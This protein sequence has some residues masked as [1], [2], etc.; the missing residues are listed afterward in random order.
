[1]QCFQSGPEGKERLQ[2]GPSLVDTVREPTTSK[3]LRERHEERMYSQAVKVHSAMGA[4]DIRKD[5]ANAR[6][7]KMGGKFQHHT[8]DTYR[9]AKVS[10][11]PQKQNN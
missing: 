3:R 9:C 4:K 8:G 10:T 5:S 1:V 11:R 2:G 6:A 7:K